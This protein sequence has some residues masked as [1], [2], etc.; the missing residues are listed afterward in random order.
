MHREGISFSFI[1][2]SDNVPAGSLFI[3]DGK[4]VRESMPGLLEGVSSPLV[5]SRLP[6]AQLEP[7]LERGIPPRTG[8]YRP[9]MENSDEGWTR[10]VLDAAESQHTSVRNAGI[11]AGDLRSRNDCLVLP[12]MST[13]AIVEGQAAGA[14]EPRYAGG[15]GNDGAT[16]LQY[17]VRDGGTLVCIDE[18]CNLPIEVFGLPVVNLLKGLPHEEFFCR[19]SS[20]RLRVD[21]GHPVGYGMPA[22]ASAYFYEAQAFDIVAPGD[23]GGSNGGASEALAAVVARYAETALVESGRI[24][25]GMELIAGKAAIVDVTYGAGHVVLLGFRVQRNAQT[26]GTFRFLYNSIQ[27]STQA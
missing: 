9:W 14:T 11:R 18:A 12:S 10:F 4:R 27:R 23:D 24:R 16:N 2:S 3:D 26:H 6:L 15:I 13:R 17:F 25:Q 22:W 20:L 21:T 5:N 19:G 8:V 1:T 7:I